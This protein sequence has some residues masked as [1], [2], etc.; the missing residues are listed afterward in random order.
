MFVNKLFIYLFLLQLSIQF[1]GIFCISSGANEPIAD[2]QLQ[3]IAKDCAMQYCVDRDGLSLWLSLQNICSGQNA[4][5][6]FLEINSNVSNDFSP[7]LVGTLCAMTSFIS[8][9][10]GYSI[11]HT[12]FVYSKVKEEDNDF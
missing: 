9:L 7:F 1:V 6:Y 3:L 5:P 12:S 11:G 8:F 4:N 2:N 10:F